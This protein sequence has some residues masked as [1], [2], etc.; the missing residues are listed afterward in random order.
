LGAVGA[1]GNSPSTPVLTR[2]AGILVPCFWRIEASFAVIRLTGRIIWSFALA[3]TLSGCLFDTRDPY[4][5]PGNVG[6]GCTGISLDVPEAVF[7]AMKCAVES[8]QD[9]AYERAI[10]PTF[11]FSPTQQDSLDQTF[12]GTDV[13]ANWTK[14][15]EMNV[16]G[17]LLSDAQTLLVEFN[18]SIL[19]NQ[20]TFVR[21]RVPYALAVVNVATPTDTT[22]YEGVAQFD[23]RNEGGNWRLTFWDE[24]ETVPN[25][26][27]WGYLKGILRLRLNP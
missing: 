14:D 18:P 3:I 13:Y 11:V 9:A 19:I 6:G 16:L 27:T 21:F 10:S 20:N 12:A 23:V 24:V 8:Q 7:E 5:P 17:L 4:P 15:V 26:S 25:R 2:P 1:L 22:L